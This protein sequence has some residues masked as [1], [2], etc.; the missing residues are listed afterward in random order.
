MIQDFSKNEIL[1]KEMQL[2]H[3]FVSD[4]TRSGLGWGIENTN[5][6]FWH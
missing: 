5:H 6:T 2:P 4:L 3:G 1:D